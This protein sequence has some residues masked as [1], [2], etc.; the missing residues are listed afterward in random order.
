MVESP[1]YYHSLSPVLR[2][3]KEF[4][5]E[6][7]PLNQEVIYARN[8]SQLPDYL[9]KAATVDTSTIYLE[10]PSQNSSWFSLI[11]PN[12]I[13]N[14]TMEFSRFLEIF[15]VN[16]STLLEPSQC[17]ALKQ[18]LMNRLAII[19]GAYSDQRLFCRYLVST[20]VCLKLLVVFALSSSMNIW[21]K[22]N[23]GPLLATLL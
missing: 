14:G 13:S 23:V 7:F 4:D 3:L 8:S 22:F 17:Q 20:F 9:Q 5:M 18:A 19:Q 12:D 1:T 16:S 6:N 2:S 10:K 15:N 21:I 11:S